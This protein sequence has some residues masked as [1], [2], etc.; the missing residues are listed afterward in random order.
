MRTMSKSAVSV[1]RSTLVKMEPK[2]NPIYIAKSA[3]C[4]SIVIN[5]YT[6]HTHIHV[7]SLSLFLSLSLSV[8]II[9][10]DH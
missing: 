2:K 10:L 5:L 4:K 9:F 1:N 3:I 6:T 8:F 7:L